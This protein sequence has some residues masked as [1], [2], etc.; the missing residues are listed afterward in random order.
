VE[1]RRED[2]RRALDRRGLVKVR[3]AALIAVY[4]EARFIEGCIEH[5][6][7]QGMHVY[8]IDNASEDD[9][10]DI[11]RR[12]L[13]RGVIG[14]ETM[15]RSGVFKLRDV[16]RRKEELAMTLDADWFMHCDADEIRLAPP[17][18]APTLAEGFAEAVR[19]GYN[20][21]NFQEF[22]FVPTRESPDHDHPRF[23]ETM[24]WY[25]PFLPSFPHRRNAWQKQAERV[26]LVTYAG[27]RVVFPG[28]RMLPE[29]FILRHYLFLSAEHANRKYGARRHDPEALALGWH[30][31]REAY[32]PQTLE[33]PSADELRTYVSDDALDARDPRTR[34]CLAPNWEQAP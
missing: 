10:A 9:T 28:L 22:T 17:R 24:H 30:G 14:I 27:H 3:A 29:P 34:H 16:L 20:A 11:V 6:V 19:R 1:S 2:E 18:F 23:R 15:P 26:D 8:V 33:L 4:N 13:G 31:W 21:V 12:H 5:L 25:Y 7:E 32:T